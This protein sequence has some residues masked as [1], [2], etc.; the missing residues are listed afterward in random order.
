M[1]AAVALALHV[2]PLNG[3]W[4]WQWPWRR[5]DALRIVPAMALAALPFFAAQWLR[6]RGTL[7]DGGALALVALSTFL[8][9]GV[10]IAIQGPGFE[11]GRIVFAVQHPVITSYFTDAMA[12]D[13]VAASL[14]RYPELMGELHLHSINKPP[15]PVLY[16]KGWLALLT[17][18]RAA[19]LGGLAIGVLAAAAVPATFALARRLGAG[20][21][22][23]FAAASYL[24]LCPGLVLF[25]P[26]FDQ[27]YPLLTCGLVGSL[28]LALD[29]GRARWAL[30]LGGLL[31]VAAFFS[32]GLGVLGVFMAGQVGVWLW[33]NKGR[34]RVRVARPLLLAGLCLAALYGALYLATGYDPMATFDAAVANQARHSLTLG[35]PWPATV[36]FDLWDFALGTGWMSFLLVGFWL[37]RRRGARPRLE[38]DPMVWLVV[39]QVAV[40]A[41]GGL[42]PVET[43]RVWLFLVPLWVLPVGLELARFRP[44]AR[45]S[46][47]VALWVLLVLVGQ[48]LVF[49]GA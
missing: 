1:V 37:A 49:L 46:V 32:F 26:E 13:G 35:R 23:A 9:E 3:P 47:F 22:A 42:I 41:V 14:A 34:D 43:A 21:E 44:A 16:Y 39:A 38:T 5:I 8:L 30:A 7:G 27:A 18:F 10:A 45:L 6:A 4:Y 20:R 29:T 19:L 25:F 12:L 15:G 33:R 11:L 2:E 17:P 36:V 24:A 48:N 28:S 31:F 40:V